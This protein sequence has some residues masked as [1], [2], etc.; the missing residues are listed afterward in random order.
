MVAESGIGRRM[1]HNTRPGLRICSTK[2]IGGACRWY[3]IS[4]VTKNRLVMEQ[5]CYLGILNVDSQGSTAITRQ[6]S[7]GGIERLIGF[8]DSVSGTRG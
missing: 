6:H 2:G 5:S 8:A 1:R 7:A 3:T 4:S